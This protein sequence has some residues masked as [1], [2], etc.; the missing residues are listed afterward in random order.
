ML[1]PSGSREI[2]VFTSYRSSWVTVALVAYE[3]RKIL[4]LASAYRQAIL[5]SSPVCFIE[6][7]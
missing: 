7:K 2:T 6:I 1:N 5:T 3:K 4:L